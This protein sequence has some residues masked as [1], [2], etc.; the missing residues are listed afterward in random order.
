MAAGIIVPDFEF[1]I[2][3]KSQSNKIGKVITLL[4]NT[5]KHG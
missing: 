5:V 4:D 3:D 2:C 1:F